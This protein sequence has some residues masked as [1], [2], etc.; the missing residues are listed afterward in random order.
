MP[1]RPP[2]LAVIVANAITG[3]SR[4]QKVA[5]S[6]ARDGWEVCLIGRSPTGKVQR[7]RIG[8]VQVIRVPVGN[9]LARAENARRK[10]GTRL[11]QPGSSM[12]KGREAWEATFESRQR[13]RSEQISLLGQRGTPLAS[14]ARFGLRGVSYLD[15]LSHRAKEDAAAWDLARRPDPA[16]PVGDWRHDQ[17]NLLDLDLAFGP[18]I[19]RFR[20]DV[21]H[22]NDITMLNTVAIAAARL[23][24]R[25]HPVSWIYDAHEYVAGVDWP[26]PRMASAYPELEREYIHRADAVVTVSPEIAEIIQRD[27]QLATRPLVVRNTPVREAIGR[28]SAVSVRTAADLPAETP[29]LVYSGYIQAQRGLDTAIDALPL[30]PE[31]HLVIVANLNNPALTKLLRR[32]DRVQVADRVHAVPYV[33]PQD[34]ADYLSSADLGIICS[35]KTINYELSLPTKLAEYIHAGLPV[36]VSDVKT[37]SAYVREHGIGSV[38]EAGQPESFAT[39]VRAALADREAR[40]TGITEEMLVDLSWEHQAEGLLKLYRKVSGLDPRPRTDL[41]WDV[42]E[43]KDPPRLLN[44]RHERH[45]VTGEDVPWRR[46][47]NTKIKLG[48]GMGNYAGQLAA[49]A[50]A[51]TERNEQVSAEVITRTA[52]TGFG[53]PSD[54]YLS[55]RSLTDLEVQLDLA[56]RVLSRYTHLISDAFLPILGQL[57]GTD[58]SGDLP[59]LTRAGIK[60][61]LL[62]H[63][64][65]I[66][67][68]K[69]HLERLPYSHFNNASDDLLEARIRAV[70]HNADIVA[71]VDLPIFVTTPDLLDDVPKATWI[72]L[73]VDVDA[74]SCEVPV[75]ERQRPVVLHAPS[76][77]WTKGTDLF[78]PDLEEMDARGV[79]ELRLVEGVPWTTMRDQVQAADIV[80]DQVAIG[81]YGTL[82]CEAMAAGKPVVVH[83]TPTVLTALGGTPPLVNTEPTGVRAAIE[84]LLD[85]RDRARE[86]GREAHDFVRVTHDGRRSAE[87]LGGFLQS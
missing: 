73:V 53:Y 43:V 62:C 45:A 11:L 85:D 40:R 14:A 52:G 7:S 58:I 24:R 34:V 61:A 16:A 48:M 65:E 84:Q 79:I 2:R 51:V 22:V 70:Q 31:V 56:R 83:L 29:L 12:S 37:L 27:H 4:V 77:R 15:R 63:G 13:L 46:M 20:P 82:A 35:A 64:S 18:Y 80:V 60:T 38:F 76:K 72:P 57:N 3:D 39:A 36:V 32:A 25:G 75:F 21:I 10:T 8:A 68:P 5:L 44:T 81:S 9:D 17:P 69:R 74:W 71:Q 59:A 50:Q 87:L 26:T 6:A 42:T 30:L 86:I 33:D 67:D 78:L 55:A 54:I 1:S 23:R 47:G 41:D 19:E 66:R 49:L 28:D